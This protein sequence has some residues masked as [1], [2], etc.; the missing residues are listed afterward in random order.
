MTKNDEWPNTLTGKGHSR[1]HLLDTSRQRGQFELQQRPFTIST[2]IDALRRRTS[3]WD[4]EEDKWPAKTLQRRPAIAAFKAT[5][6][7]PE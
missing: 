5:A 2:L 6:S 3:L 4:F 1:Q 7:R